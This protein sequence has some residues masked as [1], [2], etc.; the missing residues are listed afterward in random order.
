ML[1]PGVR[2]QVPPRAPKT[3]KSVD[4][5]VFL[6]PKVTRFEKS[7]F[8][9][10]YKSAQIDIRFW[11]G[12]K[13][14]KRTKIKNAAELKRLT[15]TEAKNTFLQHCKV[16]NL[17]VSTLEYY[18][19]DIEYFI[20]HIEQRFIHE[21]TIDVYEEF[22]ARELDEGK[23][24]TSLNSRIRGLR[25][26]FKFCAERDYME[27]LTIKLMKQDETVKEPYTD[28]EL[29]KL[30]RRPHSNSWAE[31]R[32]WAAINYLVGTGNRASTLINLRVKDIDF[33][34]MNI[35]LSKLKNRR[36][37]Y[38]PLSPSLKTV[39]LDY[40]KTWDYIEEDYLFGSY[41]GQQLNLRSLQSAIGRYNISRGVTKTSIHLFRH[42]F[43][44]NYI[45]AG[46]GMVQL[47]ALLGHSTLDMTRHYVNLY[48]Q[49]LHRGYEQFNPLD[50][51]M[52]KTAN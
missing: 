44:K 12:E 43:A 51:F 30:L 21:I 34:N 20:A 32:T 41:T 25:V 45:M 46:G 13:S 47:Q 27:P 3:P 23:K 35:F 26:F 9:E 15:V 1:T 39:L 49:D 6:F 14:M 18:K 37:Q 36:Q 17:S 38:V 19:E 16:K 2:V 24:I 48:G 52:R 10:I 11:K 28:A 8:E 50:V 5:G 7:A 22:L 31:W 33:E 40:L 4:F 42:T 29:A